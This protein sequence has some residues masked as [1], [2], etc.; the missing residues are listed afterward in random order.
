MQQ[1]KGNLLEQAVAVLA[2]ACERSSGAISLCVHTL[3]GDAFHLDNVRAKHGGPLVL[4]EASP[5]ACE[6]LC[7]VD[8]LIGLFDGQTRGVFE[9]RGS[10]DV[11]ERLADGLSLSSHNSLSVRFGR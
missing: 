11:L 2:I 6:V 5:A 3:Q 7:D 8:G 9:W 10:A 4:R 1:T